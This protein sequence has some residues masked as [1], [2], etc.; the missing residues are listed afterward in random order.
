MTHDNTSPDDTR[1]A[2]VRWSDLPLAAKLMLVSIVF[3]FVGTGLIMPFGVTYLHEVRHLS[4]QVTG[5]LLA[6]PRSS[7]CS[8][9][10]PAV[11]S[12]TVSVRV[13][14]SS[15]PSG[16]RSPGNCSWPGRT[17]SGGPHWH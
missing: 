2:R 11:S 1:A 9:S 16:S 3:D 13:A 8:P 14:S 5:I 7:G 6:C 15:R 12:S 4:L 10:A 17:T